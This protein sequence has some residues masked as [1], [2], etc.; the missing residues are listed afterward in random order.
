MPKNKIDWNKVAQQYDTYTVGGFNPAYLELLNFTRSRFN[1]LKPGSLVADIGGGTANFSLMLAEKFPESTF[2]VFDNSIQM[3]KIGEKKASKLGLEN[4]DFIEGDAEEVQRITDKYG[5]GLSHALMI[6]ALYTTGD[7]FDPKP[8][9]ILKKIHDNLGEQTSQLLLMDINKKF[10]TN[11]WIKY[12]IKNAY[13][14]FRE[15]GKGP[16]KAIYDVVKL[17]IEN[18]QAKWVN[19][20]IDRK[21]KDGEYLLCNLKELENLVIDA[22]FSAIIESTDRMYRGRDNVIL[23]RK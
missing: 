1:Q 6:H 19:R 9:R 16:I 22:G 8:K 15:N 7:Y 3:M 4:I 11:D 13:T 20:E 10:I 12:S 2:V 18:D 5:K 17:F 23:A 14:M 21:Q